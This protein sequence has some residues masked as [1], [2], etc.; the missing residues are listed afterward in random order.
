MGSIL[1]YYDS[2]KEIPVFGFGGIVPP[3]KRASHCFAVNGDIFDP[4]VDG[5]DGVVK[6]YKNALNNVELNGPTH[7]SEVIKT[8]ADMA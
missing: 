2:D 6:V 1:Q 5:I 7:F 3:L 4:E 8:V